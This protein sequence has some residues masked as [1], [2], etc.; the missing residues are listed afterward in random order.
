[1]VTA[2]E[3]KGRRDNRLPGS[4]AGS[5]PARTAESDAFSKAKELLSQ[6]WEPEG[7]AIGS[8]AAYL[9]CANGIIES[10]VAKA[11]TKATRETAT[12]RNWATVLKLQAM[13]A[14]GEAD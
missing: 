12:T 3:L 4:S 13:L 14:D 9:W 11:F 7:L 5:V 1:V 6:A 2:S 8:R 10:R